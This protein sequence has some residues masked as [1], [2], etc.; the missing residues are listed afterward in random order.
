MSASFRVHRVFELPSRGR[1]VMGEIVD[2]SVAPGDW[3][4][5][6]TGAPLR[7]DAVDTVRDARA[8]DLPPGTVALVLRDPP[9]LAEVERRLPPGTTVVLSAPLGTP[10][11]SAAPACH[12]GLRRY[13]FPL[14]TGLG[15]GI[16]AASDDE[17]RERAI[18]AQRRTAA[19]AT[20]LEPIVDVDVRTLDAGHVQ[21][22][23]GPVVV[24]GVWFP[25]E[26]LGW[27]GR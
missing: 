27:G 18:D 26:N 13:W 19:D 14:S 20:L 22:N 1:V 16:T 25:R 6:A 24:R 5:P 8:S 3:M 7:V 9:P 12:R 4:V 2:G 17:A 10:V 11:G 21:P 23:I 15:I